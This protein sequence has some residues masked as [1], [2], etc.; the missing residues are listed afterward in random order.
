[1]PIFNFYAFENKASEE[2]KDLF[3]AQSD[4]VR[5]DAEK[6]DAV[7][8]EIEKSDAVNTDLKP[9][10]ATPEECLGNF[11]ETGHSLELPI[12]KTSGS[13]DEKT[14]F[15]DM[16]KCEVARHE[17]G[18]ILMT[19]E[20]NKSKHTTINKKD[21]EH[22]HHP[23]ST[24]L[25]DN[26]PGH[27]MIGIERNAAFDNPDKLADILQK[28]INHLLMPYGRKIEL[29]KLKKNS[30]EFW[31]VIDR[32]RTH[33][34]DEVRQIRLDLSSKNAK[35]AAEAGSLMCLISSLAQKTE[36]AASLILQSE[37]DKEVKLQ[38]IYDDVSHIAAICMEHKGYDLMVK[39]K[40]FGVYRYGA[41]L[42]AMFGV[43]DEVLNC[44]GTG[45]KEF[46][47]DQSAP[48]YGL[49]IWFDKLNT[50]L[51]DYDKYTIQA[52]RKASRRRKIS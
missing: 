36:S 13:G 49:S 31:P 21:V 48:V 33:Y 24:V 5:T 7:K 29:L 25:I 42:L 40:K 18:V 30:K 34:Q 8:T 16:H 14:T 17:D 47:F 28:G 15:W 10:Y 3:S 50:L 2:K 12:L 38:E 46:C 35:E 45:S 26:R 44:F 23:Y 43:D 22:Q 37:E 6:F 32:L 1:M 11:F 51:N 9:V 19:V 27:Q 4:A 20:A 39:F 41:D 52:K